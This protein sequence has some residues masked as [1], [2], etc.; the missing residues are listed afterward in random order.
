MAMQ[1]I[2]QVLKVNDVR[3]GKSGDRTW[4]SQDCEAVTRD[5]QGGYGQVGRLRLPKD[6]IGRVSPGLFMAT[7]AMARDESKEGGGRLEARMV[8][9]QPYTLKGEKPGELKPAA[10]EV[11]AK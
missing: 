2:I 11:A 1:S 6:L 10:A 4:Q 9:L 8:G 5:D 7:F 3:D